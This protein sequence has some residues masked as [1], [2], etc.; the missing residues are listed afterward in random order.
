[1]NAV[2][3]SRKNEVISTE[4]VCNHMHVHR[5]AYYKC[6]GRYNH[7]KSVDTKVVKL[8]KEE[9]EIQPRVGT[10]KLQKHLKG[11]FHELQLKVGRDRL[12]DVLREQGMLVNR[13]KASIKTTNSYP[14]FHKYI[15]LIKDVKITRPNQ[16]W[17][18]DITYIRTVKG[19]CYLALITD[20]YSR[21]IV[22]FDVSDS[23]EQAGCLR[24]L[25]KALANSKPA[26]G[27][28]HHSDRG[29]HYC[30]T[31][32]VAKLK[33]RKIKISMTEENHCYEN[34]VAE[35]VNGILK[36]EFY[37]DQCFVRQAMQRRQLKMQLTSITIKDY[38]YL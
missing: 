23:L 28:I 16:V 13:K 19:F 17:V 33:T 7:R 24:A 20:L 3:N 5:D 25:Q 31:Q 4:N 37:L 15:N 1:M 27:L 9:R 8:V 12:F 21:K 6:K 18:S 38:T 32:Y 26:G 11:A 35:R 2:E 10:R 30:S 34:A 22:G 36:D 29:I 14:H